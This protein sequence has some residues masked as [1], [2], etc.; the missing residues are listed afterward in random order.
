MN[1]ITLIIGAHYNN[2]IIIA[3]DRRVTF[4]YKSLEE[5]SIFLVL[6]RRIAA[7]FAGRLAIIQD[8]IRK[9][10]ENPA[11]MRAKTIYEALE[12]MKTVISDISLKYVQ[13]GTFSQE[14]KTFEAFICGL[15]RLDS[16]NPTLFRLDHMG[17][18]EK[19]VESS[20]RP[21]YISGPAMNY[22]ASL[23][24]LLYVEE[25]S[26]EGMISLASHIILQTGLLDSSVGAHPQIVFVEP[27]KLP[28]ILDDGEIQRIVKKVRDI[29]S[30]LAAMQIQELLRQEPQIARAREKVFLEE[31]RKCHPGKESW[32]EYEKLI[33]EIFSYLFVP[34]LRTP[35]SQ[36]RADDGLEIRDLIFPNT[37][38]T[39]FWKYVRTEYRGTYIVVEVKNKQGATKNDV[40]QIS[41]Y[42]RGKQLGLFGLLVSRG[43][44]QSALDQRRKEYSTEP[45]KM[46]VL[47]DDDDVH[48]MI[49]KKIKGDN[50]E[51]VIRDRIDKYRIEYRF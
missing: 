5:S 10:E 32:R 22:A 4:G 39:G 41:D 27:N 42:L 45:S 21:Y 43:I 19:L 11:S 51:D 29:S 12:V 8:F 26:K 44:S 49:L 1:S 15:E 36:S 13:R 30:A 46:I 50:P 33:E 2:G 20:E 16:G 25:I 18:A 31:L 9:F 14:E 34:P 28:E 6:R 7:A 48:E 23:M 24:K 38:D 17:Y 37:T 3:A 40:I 47:L 35:E